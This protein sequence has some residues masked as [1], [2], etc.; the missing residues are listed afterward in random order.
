MIECQRH[1]FTIPDDITYLDVACISPL[2]KEVC[3]AG[4]AGVDRKAEPWKLGWSDFFAETE[5]AR[6]EFAR[7][8]GAA[9]DDIAI[10]P[11]ASYGLRVAALNVPAPRGS[12]IIVLENQFSSN[13]FVWQELAKEQGCEIVTI[14]QPT[15]W[16][17]TTSILKA[18]DK[19]VSIVAVPNC[20]WMDGSLVDLKRVGEACRSVGAALVVDATQ[21]LGAFPLDVSEVKPDFLVSAA[22]KWLLGPYSIGFMYAA[23]ERQNGR[24]LEYS[25]F[26]RKGIDRVYDSAAQKAGLVCIDELAPSARR[27]D[28]G[29]RSN[30]ILLPMAITALRQIIGWQV[31]R[32]AE[33]LLPLTELIHTLGGELGLA[34]APK[35]FRAAHMI[36][37]RA[38]GEWPDGFEQRLRD[39]K[40]YASLRGKNLRIAPHLYNTEADIQ[41][42]FDVLRQFSFI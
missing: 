33:T 17:W 25:A 21:S 29:E 39:E 11:A 9:S 12:R 18:I 4:Y 19:N 6:A 41:K 28:V 10:I 8:I 3:R 13:L 30:F 27:Y 14:S 5:V 1:L 31:P 16:D 42:L 37:L 36:G 24:P 15:D 7:L 32:I 20:H 38:P 40:I 34:S 35:G 22:Y 23:P 2:M 26:A